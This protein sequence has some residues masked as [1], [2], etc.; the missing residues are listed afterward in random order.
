MGGGSIQLS[1]TSV[2]NDYLTSNSNV[3]FFKKVYKQHTIFSIE[4]I[5]VDFDDDPTFGRETRVRIPRNGDLIHQ[6]TLEITLPKI[7]TSGAANTDGHPN[8]IQWS[9]YLALALIKDIEIEIGGRTIDKHTGE[10]MCINEFLR[11]NMSDQALKMYGHKDNLYNIQVST[12]D[13]VQ[14][15]DKMYVPLQFWFNR[16]SQQALPLIALSY[17]DVVLK[18]EFERFEKVCHIGPTYVM[19]NYTATK[20]SGA[21]AGSDVIVG[22]TPITNS[23]GKWIGYVE[24]DWVGTDNVLYYH[25]AAKL[26]EIHVED[27]QGNDFVFTATLSNND[28]VS[29]E[30]FKFNDFDS[31]VEKDFFTEPDFTARLLVNYIYLDAP[32]RMKFTNNTHE[33][34]IE[35]LQIPNPRHISASI[36]NIRLPFV[37]P[38]KE[39]I[40]YSYAID[41]HSL[42][43]QKWNFLNTPLHTGNS[44]LVRANVQFNGYDR[45]TGEKIYFEK[46]HPMKYHSGLPLEGV[47]VY[48][49]ALY[50]EKLEPSGAANYS[51]IDDASLLVNYAWN[52]KWLNKKYMFNVF[53]INYNLLVIEGGMGGLRFSA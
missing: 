46:I 37:H 21:T 18:I 16:R 40:W 44:A 17:H 52:S 34:L 30:L 41:S 53:A 36:Q 4:S 29:K 11:D 27:A 47:S 31:S 33:Y 39:M 12:A 35:T 10:A 38:V 51:A 13:F 23:N 50:P 5:P 43:N 8:T 32:E 25:S 48:S 14:K 15:E 45:E 1:A 26:T 22:G 3:T 42:F 49:F 7:V 9:K 28:V 2:A 24:K 6:I 20:N 19:K